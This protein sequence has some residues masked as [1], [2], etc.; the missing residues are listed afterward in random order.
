MM[1]E[2]EFVLNDV[3]WGKWDDLFIVMLR[4]QDDLLAK[5]IH[6]FLQAYYYGDDQV[7]MISTHENLLY[8]LHHAIDV[9][10]LQ[11]TEPVHLY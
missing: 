10:K 11:D 9:Q 8:Y 1:H 3:M 6:L 7:D 5:K 2:Y 4:T